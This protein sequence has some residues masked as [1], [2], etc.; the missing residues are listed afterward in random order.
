M[1][2]SSYLKL[3]GKSVIY[4]AIELDISRQ[5]IYQLMNGDTA[6]PK[7]AQKIEEWSEGAIQREELLYPD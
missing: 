3:T 4:A 6:S 7:L 1:K 2:I 5:R